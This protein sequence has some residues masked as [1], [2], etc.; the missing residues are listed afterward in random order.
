MA[1]L[2]VEQIIK[3][4]YSGMDSPAA[5]RAREQMNKEKT[6]AADDDLYRKR[7]FLEYQNAGE[8]EKQ[9]LA[10]KGA[11]ARQSLANEGTTNVANINAKAQM[12]SEDQ[13]LTGDLYKTNR[14]VDLAKMSDATAREN[15]ANANRAGIIEKSDSAED[16]RS[17]LNLFSPLPKGD[18][19][20]Y[21]TPDVATPTQ[22]ASS[23]VQTAAPLPKTVNPARAA[24]S[25]ISQP[26]STVISKP[27][28]PPDP[29]T[30]SAM[31]VNVGEM[32]TPGN[33]GAYRKAKSEMSKGVS[34]IVPPLTEEQRKRR[35]KLGGWM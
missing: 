23:P 6:W 34:Q 18:S 26:T 11:L 33:V 1:G 13:R 8:L 22:A 4:I 3:D 28:S 20:G 15:A 5:R 2:D 21:Q 27:A 12:Y 25:N 7:K 32:L 31:G 10:D 29:H 19:T 17:K 30:T 9:S 16:A 14:G 35:E 24:L